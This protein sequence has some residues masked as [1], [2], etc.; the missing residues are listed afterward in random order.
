M[1]MKNKNIHDYNLNMLSALK[2]KYKLFKVHICIC[3]KRAFVRPIIFTG[4][5][6]SAKSS[7]LEGFCPPCHFHGRAFVRLVIF[8]GGLL[9]TF[10][11]FDVRAFVLHSEAVKSHHVYVIRDIIFPILV[12]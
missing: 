1:P 10:S 5:L 12:V 3:C 7:L 2:R 9:S 11:L 6:L 8:T 4:G